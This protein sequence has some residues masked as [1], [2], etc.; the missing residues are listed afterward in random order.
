VRC[1]IVV[2]TMGRATSMRQMT[3]SPPIG[4]QTW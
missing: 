4:S 2:G 3:V 1:L